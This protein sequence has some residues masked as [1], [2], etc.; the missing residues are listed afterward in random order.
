VARFARSRSI[1]DDRALA[2]WLRERYLSLDELVE[3]LRE[4]DLEQR[5]LAEESG[6]AAI[7][8]SGRGRADAAR[9]LLEGIR[10]RNGVDVSPLDLPCLMHPGVPWDGPLLRELKVRGQFGAALTQAARIL[11]RCDERIRQHPW[12]TFTLVPSRAVDAWLADRWRQPSDPG[13]RAR[14]FA[15]YDDLLEAAR[16]V[17]LATA[18]GGQRDAPNRWRVSGEPRPDREIPAGDRSRTVKDTWGTL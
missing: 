15:S 1:P 11:D 6:P 10:Q 16:Y 5:L 18:S 12:L 3:V 4:R 17:Y 2:A 8:R 13:L 9:R 14:G 7:G